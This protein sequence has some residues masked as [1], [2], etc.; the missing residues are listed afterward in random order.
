MTLLEDGP[1][2]GVMPQLGIN[3]LG[4]AGRALVLGGGQQDEDLEQMSTSDGMNLSC[5]PSIQV[6]RRN[7]FVE[8]RIKW[9]FGIVLRY[10]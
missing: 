1:P 7:V 3:C 10:A 2:P 8:K 6:W 9:P 5:L 4:F